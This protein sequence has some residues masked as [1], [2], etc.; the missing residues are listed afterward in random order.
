[1]A[2]AIHEVR[3]ILGT[4][5]FGDYELT[6]LEKHHLAGEAEILAKM[7]EVLHS[8]EFLQRLRRYG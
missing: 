6:T 5:N 1:M 4:D 8:D 2:H 7:R 3:A